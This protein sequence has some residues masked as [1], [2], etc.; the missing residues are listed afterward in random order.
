MGSRYRVDNAG[1]WSF[2]YQIIRDKAFLKHYRPNV[3]W[4]YVACAVLL[5]LAKTGDLRTETL[6]EAYLS[7]KRDVGRSNKDGEDLTTGDDGKTLN[8]KRNKNGRD[9]RGK[10]KT[11]ITGV[12]NNVT[13][14]GSLLVRVH[15]TETDGSLVERYYILPKR[16]VNK[17]KTNGNSLRISWNEKKH[18]IV[19]FIPYKVSRDKIFSITKK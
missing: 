7:F 15:V 13:K 16:Y 11:G 6:F 14:N 19:K 1:E 10:Q 4:T 8:L 12:I 18:E 17:H 9:K 5:E 3:K 2:A